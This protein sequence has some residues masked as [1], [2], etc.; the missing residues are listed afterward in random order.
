VL[1][2]RAAAGSARCGRRAPEAGALRANAISRPPN[3]FV[4]QRHLQADHEFEQN[5][6]LVKQTSI[7]SATP[8]K[9]NS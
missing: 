9:I 1:A 6:L 4:T 3:D 8:N 2:G 5:C 7:V